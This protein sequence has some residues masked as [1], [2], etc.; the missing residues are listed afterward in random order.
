MALSVFCELCKICRTRF[1]KKTAGT[2]E[3]LRKSNIKNYVENEIKLFFLGDLVYLYVHTRTFWLENSE[4]DAHKLFSRKSK[5]KAHIIILKKYAIPLKAPET[6]LQIYK[7]N[8]F[9]SCT[10]KSAIAIATNMKR[11]YFAVLQ[12][13]G[14]RNRKSKNFVSW[15]V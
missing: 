10:Q 12:V 1:I 8:Y 4:M 2:L 5:T 15:T 3:R 7:N 6:S 9:T 13:D 11:T 14:I